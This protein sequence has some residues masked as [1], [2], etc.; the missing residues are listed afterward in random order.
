MTEKY[1]SGRFCSRACANS[2]THDEETKQKISESVLRTFELNPDKFPNV[3][4][5]ET[6]YLNPKRCIICDAIL[7]FERRKRKLCASEECAKEQRRRAA[8]KAGIANAKVS[9]PKYAYAGYYNDI[10]LRQVEN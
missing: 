7:P 2:R 4:S 8:I 10:F 1:G 5:R 3:T 6:Y 9:N